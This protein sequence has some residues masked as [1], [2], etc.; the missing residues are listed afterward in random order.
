[1]TGSGRY[2]GDGGEGEPVRHRV[3]CDV[4][5]PVHLPTHHEH[6][7]QVGT[8]SEPPE[9]SRLWTAEEVIEA[10]ARGD[11][12]YT[13]SPSTGLAGRIEIDACEACGRRIIR[14]DPDA[15]PDSDLTNL[16]DCG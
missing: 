6:V 11:S 5:V 8:S 16:A 4:Q 2:Q 10:V 12:F 9:A 7:A 1:M 3:V 15:T 14:S 13:R